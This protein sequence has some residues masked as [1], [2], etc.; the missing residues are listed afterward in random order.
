M[1]MQNERVSVAEKLPIPLMK[2]RDLTVEL[3]TD[4][5]MLRAVD[6]VSFDLHPGR[7]M[8]I[9]GESGSGKSICC[10]ALVRLLPRGANLSGQVEF[11]GRD[12]VSLPEV[13]MRKVRGGRIGYIFQDP[14]ASLNPSISI[15]AQIAEAMP[16]HRRISR[17]EA[18]NRAVELLS[19]VGIPAASRRADDYPYEFSGGMRQR[20]LIALALACDP[21]ML[22]ADEPTTALD[23][24]IQAQILDLLRDMRDQLSVSIL[25]VTHDLGVVAD[26][27]DEALVLYGGEVVE[28]APDLD[29]FYAGP[30]HPYAANLLDALKR[31]PKRPLT[32]IP[33]APPALGNWPQGCRYSPRCAHVVS[34]CTTDHPNLTDCPNPGGQVRCHLRSGALA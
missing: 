32:T 21:A 2:V 28:H 31:D 7:I 10:N 25:F 8:G 34:R 1:T 22:I 14:M 12:L 3:P 29:R 6:R 18:K 20:A 19:M 4:R 23:V 16:L 30:T 15:G 9:V 33:G 13:E 5:G 17:R 27:C 11:E 26:I 24:T